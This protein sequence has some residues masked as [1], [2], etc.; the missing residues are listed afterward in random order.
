M[1]SPNKF[2]KSILATSIGIMLGTVVMTPALA[3]EADDTEVIQVR[4][5]RG[6]LQESMSIKRESKGIVD[7]ISAEDI[8]KFPDSNLAES[9]QRITGVSIDRNNGEGDKITVRGFGGDNNMVTLNGR[10]MPAAD[11]WGNGGGSGRA[12]SFANLASESVRAVEVYK[13]GKANITAGGIGSTVN[14]ITAKPL[15]NEGFHASVGGKL[16]SD[17]TVDRGD[18]VTPEISGIFSFTNDDATWGVGL[19]FSNQVRHS[20]SSHSGTG[21]WNY[22]EW[23]PSYDADSDTMSYQAFSIVPGPNG[24]TNAAYTN[25]Q[26]TN[27]PADG[28]LFARPNDLRYY[29]SDFERD[30]TN[31]QLTLQ[32][33]PTDDLT[34]TLDYTYVNNEVQQREAQSGF[35]LNRSFSSVTFDTDQPVA[36]MVM[37]NE[38]VGGAKDNTATQIQTNQKN[39]IDSIGLNIEYNVNDELSFTVDIH[40]STAESLPDNLGGIGA[41]R[42][43][44]GLAAPLGLTQSYDFSG[45]FPTLAVTIDDCAKNRPAGLP[46]CNGVWDTTDVGTNFVRV[47]DSSQTTDISQAKLDGTYMFDEGQFD[48]GIETR[49]IEMN[50]KNSQNLL[51]GGDWGIANPGELPPGSLEEFDLMGSFEDYNVG[52]HGITSFRGDA[53]DIVRW[54]TAQ[55]GHDFM[56]EFDSTG[57]RDHDHT[58]VEDV[59]SAYLQ[60]SLSGEVGGMETNV[61]AGVR[62]ESTDVE[63]TSVQAVPQT[64]LWQDN[65]DFVTQNSSASNGVMEQHSYN[66]VLPSLDIDVA[67]TDDIKARMSFGQTMARASYND[68]RASIS[69][70]G[71]N[72]P[73]LMGGTSNATSSNP[74]LVPLLSTNLDLSVEYYFDD[75]SYVSVGYFDK[76]VSNFIGTEQVELNHFGLRDATGGPRAQAAVDALADLGIT[77]DETHLFVMTAILDNPQDFPNGA[78]DYINEMNR[79]GNESDFEFDMAA[80]YDI[81]PNGDD[82]LYDFL[83]SR[84]VNNK[85]ANLYGAELAAQHFFG[86]TGFGLSANYTLVRGDVKYDNTAS[87]SVSQFALTG[88]SDTANLVAMYEKDGWQ[89]RVAY[90]WRDDFLQSAGTQ[91]RY[92]E[93]YSQLDFTVSYDVMEDLTVTFAG[94]NITDENQRIYGRSIR[95]PY[96]VR[97]LGARYTLGARYNF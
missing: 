70:F 97:D 2:Q 95:T 87:P 28:Q 86:E 58:V 42:M 93:A 53:T 96:T 3:Q 34:A 13:T 65:N 1:R 50:Q 72:A 74:G 83:T 41:G 78:A 43:I 49:S 18:D 26:I 77:L 62:Y 20:G 25:G 16:V 14:I 89:A 4:G 92:V 39:T 11:A 64:T 37:I 94:L 91:P 54:G 73:T 19:T 40:D 46:E 47:A 21:G 24:E 10:L 29:H 30:R 8:G 55:Y 38:D 56:T 52:N 75:T 36:T 71:H 22:A 27:A 45:E 69:G 5:I 31:A 60:Y 32:F 90:N 61:L 63:S 84:P 66:H 68:L 7:A 12:F 9:L 35:W 51:K 23:N 81:L 48:F 6:S 59:F 79:I 44:A 33:A 82:P 85:D 15:S 17:S 76:R 80:R 57:V 67:V 88:L